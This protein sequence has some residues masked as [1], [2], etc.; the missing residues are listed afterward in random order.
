MDNANTPVLGDLRS[1]VRRTHLE[2]GHEDHQKGGR[3]GSHHQAASRA[4]R[5]IGEGGK[6]G[7]RNSG[8][9]IL[10]ISLL[11]QLLCAKAPREAEEQDLKEVGEK[12]QDT[13]VT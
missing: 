12:E 4:R 5:E 2:E 11:L 9:L 8:F 7:W 10:Y 6:D 3:C 13:Q 1:P